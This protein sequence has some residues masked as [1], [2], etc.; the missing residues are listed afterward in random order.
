MLGETSRIDR[1][2]GNGCRRQVPCET[3]HECGK[4]SRG[5]HGWAHFLKMLFGIF[6]CTPMIRQ[7]DELRDRDVAGDARR[8]DTPDAWS[9]P[10]SPTRKSIISWIAAFVAIVRSGIGRHADVVG[11][12]FRARP[13]QLHVLADRQLQAGRAAT[14]RSRS[15][16]LRR[17]P[18][19][20]GRRRPRTARPAR[21]PECRA[22]MPATSSRLSRLP[23]W[24]PGGLLLTRPSSGAGATPMLPKNGLQRNHDARQEL[25]RHRLAIER[26]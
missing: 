7:V 18:A 9:G 16:R 13:R 14:S 2:I 11:R 22:S 19:R 21:T 4:N 24:R 1:D 15:D 8:A 25:R 17:R 3:Q 20:H 10:S 26:E 23:A 12:R 6:T 5:M